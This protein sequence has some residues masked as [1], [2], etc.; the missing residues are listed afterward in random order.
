MLRVSQN[1]LI[2]SS[3]IIN[4]SSFFPS[5]SNLPWY[6]CFG[7]NIM[8]KRKLSHSHSLQHLLVSHD[9][10]RRHVSRCCRL[11]RMR[12][13]E[14]S[15]PA[16]LLHLPL[17]YIRVCFFCLPTYAAH[18]SSVRTFWGISKLPTWP[19]MFSYLKYVPSFFR[20]I[21]DLLEPFSLYKF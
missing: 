12:F 15:S 6:W 13:M 16:N 7:I 20:R 14:T 19:L 8:S 18:F 3:V 9:A 10:L 5:S 17:S 11:I 2:W 1:I 4:A 21:T